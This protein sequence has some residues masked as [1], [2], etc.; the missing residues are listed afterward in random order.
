MLKLNVCHHSSDVMI[1]YESFCTLCI[2]F[3]LCLE[4]S[5]VISEKT[6][7]RKTL[8]LFLLVKYAICG[9][10]SVCGGVFWCPSSLMRPN[11]ASNV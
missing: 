4:N 5:F 1:V 2:K 6:L 11:N 9:C 7:K 3:I 8:F 10:V